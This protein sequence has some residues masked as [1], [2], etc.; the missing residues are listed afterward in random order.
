MQCSLLVPQLGTQRACQPVADTVNL[1]LGA[2]RLRRCVSECFENEAQLPNRTR[3]TQYTLLH[4]LDIG[5][6]QPVRNQRVDHGRGDLTQFVQ[7]VFGRVV[8]QQLIGM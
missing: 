6:C 5:D 8:G 1:L 3:F 2:V 7:Q 4:F